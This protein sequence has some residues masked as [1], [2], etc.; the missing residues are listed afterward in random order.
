MFPGRVVVL[1]SMYMKRLKKELSP[2]IFIYKIAF[3]YK[4][5]LF[6][7]KINICLNGHTYVD[8]CTKF[9]NIIKEK[10]LRIEN[11]RSLQIVRESLL[12]R[13]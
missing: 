2:C 10:M 12:G 5:N 13:C 8:I 11:W 3:T 4:I 9:Y 7:Y 6:T 1:E